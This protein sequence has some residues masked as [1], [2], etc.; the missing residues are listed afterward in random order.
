MELHGEWKTKWCGCL[1]K[2]ATAWTKT[3]SALKLLSKVGN[4]LCCVVRLENDAINDLGFDIELRPTVWRRSTD[5]VRE[6]CDVCSTPI[7]NFHVL[8]DKCG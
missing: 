3:Q 4:H 6:M 8:C 2:Q 7:F 1:A 5:E